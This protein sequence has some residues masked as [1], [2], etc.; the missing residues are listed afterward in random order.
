MLHT[1]YKIMGRLVMEMTI[2]K[3]YN[4]YGRGATVFS[5]M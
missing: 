2:L 4:I 5:V 1:E 3:V